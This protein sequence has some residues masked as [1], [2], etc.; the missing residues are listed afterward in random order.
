MEF[1]DI[2]FAVFFV[3]FLIACAWVGTKIPKWQRAR[4]VTQ[5]A[6]DIEADVRQEAIDMESRKKAAAKIL[7][8]RGQTP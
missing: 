1:G 7:R 2:L 6:R 5:R 4:A 3:I 8:E